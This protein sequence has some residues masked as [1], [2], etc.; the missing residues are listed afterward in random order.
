MLAT[1]LAAALRDRGVGEPAATLAARSGVTVFS[2]AYARWIAPDEDRSLADLITGTLDELI[3]VT[4]GPAMADRRIHDL[5]PRPG[6][7]RE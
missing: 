3:L 5:R 6:Q 4:A 1:G 2:V 7:V